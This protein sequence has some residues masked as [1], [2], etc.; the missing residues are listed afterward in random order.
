MGAHA[1][2]NK[3]LGMMHKVQSKNSAR[4]VIPG[5]YFLK[6]HTYTYSAAGLEP[7][8]KDFTSFVFP[9]DFKPL[10]DTKYVCPWQGVESLR[11]TGSMPACFSLS[12]MVQ[13]G[14]NILYT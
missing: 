9:W 8:F 7:A 1:P 3:P 14:C 11:P 2:R 10:N 13:L 4:P 5:N 12:Y 6:L